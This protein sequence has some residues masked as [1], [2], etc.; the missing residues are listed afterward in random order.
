MSGVWSRLEAEPGDSAAEAEPGA[1]RAVEA[2]WGALSGVV[3]PE[4]CL[5][6][7]SLGLV[8]GVAAV[9][10]TL[11]VEMTLTTPGC[12]ASES[13][14][15]LARAAVADAVGATVPVD[16]RVVWEPPWSPAMMDAEVAGALG[17]RVR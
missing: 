8:Y 12:P 6:V 13:L 2:A 1:G 3:D 15:E 5:D 7:V 11:V 14:P 16:V 10:G 9:D 4:L 17:L